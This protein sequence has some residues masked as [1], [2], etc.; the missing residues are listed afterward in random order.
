MRTFL[1]EFYHQRQCIKRERLLSSGEALSV[2]M[3]ISVEIK[4]PVRVLR[5][6]DYT[7]AKSYHGTVIYYFPA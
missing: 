2:A 5:V 3:I 6:N 4:A 1:F 7:G